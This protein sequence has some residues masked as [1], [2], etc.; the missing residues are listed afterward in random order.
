MWQQN[1]N[2]SV[3]WHVMA[4]HDNALSKAAEASNR[5]EL[6]N[7]CWHMSRGCPLAIITIPRGA[8]C[9][10]H[11]THTPPLAAHATAT[12]PCRGWRRGGPD[13]DVIVPVCGPGIRPGVRA[14]WQHGAVGPS[15]AGAPTAGP[16]PEPVLVTHPQRMTY[17]NLTA[18]HQSTATMRWHLDLRRTHSLS[19]VLPFKHAWGHFQCS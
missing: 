18:V 3:L 1:L 16:S 4:R 7:Y 8:P 14:E 12:I 2:A 5:P 15:P 11:R 10:D 19:P 9:G 17:P 13:A 6:C